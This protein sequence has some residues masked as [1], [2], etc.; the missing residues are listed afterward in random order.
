MARARNL[1]PGFFMDCDVAS[2]SVEARLLFTALWCLADNS[3]DVS[4]PPDEIKRF[5]FPY[6]DV[7]PM[8]LLSELSSQGLIVLSETEALTIPNF[9]L[10]CG[11]FPKPHNVLRASNLRRA[12]RRNA[13]VPWAVQSAIGRIYEKAAQLT[14]E[15]G[16]K[17]HVDHIIPLAGKIVCGLH[18]ESNLQILTARENLAK[19]NRWS[20]DWEIP[21]EGE[22]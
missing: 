22:A 1:K 6:D 10:W 3:G 11:P 20:P 5:A 21:Q 14:K 19:G 7:D 18:V 15:T 2:C 8:K 13:D 17:H 16:V 9:E 4:E 12:R